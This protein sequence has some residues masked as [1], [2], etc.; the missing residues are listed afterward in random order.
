VSSK[1]LGTVER[2]GHDQPRA[3]LSGDHPRF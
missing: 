1:V 2:T 3:T